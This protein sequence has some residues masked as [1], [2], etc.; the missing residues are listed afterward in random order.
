[1]NFFT[2]QTIAFQFNSSELVFDAMLNEVP[3]GQWESESRKIFYTAI[4]TSWISPNT[5]WSNNKPVE[6]LKKKLGKSNLSKFFLLISNATTCLTLA[7]ILLIY[8]YGV[9]AVDYFDIANN[10]PLAHCFRNETLNKCSDFN[11]DSNPCFQNETLANCSGFLSCFICSSDVCLSKI[12]LCENNELATYLLTVIITP[13][14]IGLLAL[15]IFISCS[16]QLLGSYENMYKLTSKYKWTTIIHPTLVLDYAKES[17]YEEIQ[18]AA[19]PIKKV[20]CRSRLDNLLKDLTKDILN[21]QNSYTGNTCFLDV[22]VK[23]FYELAREMEKIGA[24]PKIK[25]KAG[26]SVE[27]CQSTAKLEE[28]TEKKRTWKNETFVYEVVKNDKKYRILLRDEDE[29]NGKIYWSL[30][31]EETTDPFKINSVLAFGNEACKILESL[32]DIAKE[33]M[34]FICLPI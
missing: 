8:C 27:S 25:N 7:I 22:Y 28:F 24:D 32:E 34:S 5:V 13:I 21:Q 17:I 29:N 33:K 31:F 16:L 20:N 2:I 9:S 18:N 23:G 6:I 19:E 4:F 11:F 1:M 10:P 30:D 26:K 3:K 15:N 14:L 12:R